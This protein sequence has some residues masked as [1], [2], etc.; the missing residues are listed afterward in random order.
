MG[1]GGREAHEIEIHSHFNQW[2]LWSSVK[3]GVAQG[4]ALSDEMFIFPLSCSYI[5][6]KK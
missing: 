1:G 2:K 5:C 4:L 3:R 6:G